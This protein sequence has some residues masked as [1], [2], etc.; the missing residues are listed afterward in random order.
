MVLGS[1]VPDAMFCQTADMMVNS[2]RTC[3]LKMSLLL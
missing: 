3:I 1:N 2:Y